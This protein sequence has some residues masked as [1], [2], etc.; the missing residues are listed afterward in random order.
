M[1]EKPPLAV[2]AASIAGEAAVGADDAMARHDQQHGV[3]AVGRPDR[4]Y[5]CRR[6]NRPGDVGVQTRS[7]RTVRSAEQPTPASGILCRSSRRGW[8]PARPDVRRSTPARPHRLPQGPCGLRP[9]DPDTTAPASAARAPHPDRRT[10][11]TRSHCARQASGVRSANRVETAESPRNCTPS[12]RNLA[13]RRAGQCLD[14]K[15]W[16]HPRSASLHGPEQE[17]DQLRHRTLDGPLDRLERKVDY[18]S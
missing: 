7:G 13:H 8:R 18:R 15:G 9:A 10:A 17:P 12:A 5:C 3:R 2:E 1:A 4:A 14:S 16:C 6:P 11:C